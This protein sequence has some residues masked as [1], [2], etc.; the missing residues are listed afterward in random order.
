MEG[1]LEE[2][3][4]DCDE[5]LITRHKVRGQRER[6]RRRERERERVRERKREGEREGSICTVMNEL[7][8]VILYL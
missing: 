6:G 3:R 5:K 2:L 7:L 4:L 8:Y 1:E